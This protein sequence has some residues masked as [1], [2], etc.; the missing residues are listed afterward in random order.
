MMGGLVGRYDTAG[1][2]EN[3]ELAEPDEALKRYFA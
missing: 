3:Y 1:D 2:G